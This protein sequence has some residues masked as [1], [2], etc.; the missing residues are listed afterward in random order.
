MIHR[1]ISRMAV[2]TIIGLLGLVLSG[3]GSQQSNEPPAT[4]STPG[5][6]ASP[7]GYKVSFRVDPDPP[8][9]AKE[10][11]VHV[12]LQDGSGKP[13]TDAQVHVQFTMPAMPEMKMP[14]MSNGIDLSWNGTDYSGPIQITMAGGWNIDVEAKRGGEVLT[15]YQTKLTAK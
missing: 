15:K 1:Q 11:T 4:P 3:C 13:V 5:V 6:P 9:G 10:N 8:A 2:L 12:T 14:E 7:G